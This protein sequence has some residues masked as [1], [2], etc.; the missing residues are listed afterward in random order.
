MEF[1]TELV[2]AIS[3]LFKQAVIEVM[4]Q[5]PESKMGDLEQ[6]LRRLL[7]QAGE[8]ALSKGL[9]ALDS[10]YPEPQIA[11]AC[12]QMADYQFRR[13]AKT[14]TVF[15]WVEYRRAYYLCAHCHQGQYPLDQRMG[16]EPGQVSA[17]L[18]PLLALAGVE[19][20]F[21]EGCELVERFLLLEVSDNTLRKETQTFG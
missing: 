16:L 6:G 18:A 10:H 15:G 7:K 3:G 21:E 13:K 17:G 8:Q 11:C 19:T 12:G 5:Q 2:E 4:T 9:S 20:A 14:L 1:S